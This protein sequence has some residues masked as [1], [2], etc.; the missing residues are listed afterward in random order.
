[1]TALIGKLKQRGIESPY[2]RSF[3]TARINP[4]RFAKTVTDSPEELL[5]RMH[6]A[7]DT[8]DP[9]KVRPDQVSASAGYAPDEE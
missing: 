5:V 2:L 6:K 9:G 7:A 8:F 4:I 3:V 1:M